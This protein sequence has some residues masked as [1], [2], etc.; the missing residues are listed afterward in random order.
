MTIKSNQESNFQSGIIN[1]IKSFNKGNHMKLSE[2]LLTA[3]TT[4]TFGGLAMLV[5]AMNGLDGVNI[6]CF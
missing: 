1:L 5:P 2:L 6:S 4:L 3:A